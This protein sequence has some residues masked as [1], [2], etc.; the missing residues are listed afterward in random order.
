MRTIK[1]SLK[2]SKGIERMREVA[3]EGRTEVK[4]GQS[5]KLFCKKRKKNLR[6]PTSTAME[7][8]GSKRFPTPT[9]TLLPFPPRLSVRQT[10]RA[11]L[12]YVIT[13]SGSLP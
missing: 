6:V 8:Y 11:A 2:G 10:S 1:T 9:R 3:R 4:I 7:T 12:S 5:M 13:V